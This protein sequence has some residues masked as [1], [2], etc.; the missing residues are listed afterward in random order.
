[1]CCLLLFG[2][3]FSPTIAQAWGGR[4]HHVICSSAVHLVQNENLRRFLQGRPHTMGHLCNIPDIYWKSLPPS[5]SRS[6]DPA[7]FLD[8]EV[9]GLKVKNIPLDYAKIE[10]DFLGRDNRFK[11]AAKIFSVADDFGSLWWRADQF[12]RLITGRKDAFAAAKTPQNRKEEQDDKL[13]YNQEVYAMMVNMGLMGHFV[14]D[15]AQPLHNTA[16]Y[17]GYASGHGGLH[18]YFEEAVVSA[19]PANL[20]SRVYE[21]AR[22]IRKAPWLKPGPP[23]ERLRAFSAESEAE[24]PQLLGKDPIKRKSE[25]RV[26]KGMAIKTPAERHDP[27]IG[28]KRYERMITGDMARASRFLAALWDDAYAAAGKPDLSGYRSYRYPFT[29]DF[30]PLDYLTPASG[31][32]SKAQ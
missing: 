15:A 11:P 32:T 30:V 14:G 28:W 12:F 24:L 27:S 17:D 3:V 10:K 6:G 4:G 23:L 8:P 19:A 5:V 9:L 20:E 31:E 7:H 18:S 21:E 13:P 1:M 29:P 16:D 2:N 26:E 25:A 22:R